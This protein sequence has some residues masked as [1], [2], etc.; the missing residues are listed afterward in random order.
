MHE[1]VEIEPVKGSV[2]QKRCCGDKKLTGDALDLPWPKPDCQRDC[3][4]D[5]TVGAN[6]VDQPL[7]K[8]CCG[9]KTKGDG[10]HDAAENMVE[11]ESVDEL[12]TKSACQK[13]CCGDKLKNSVGEVKAHGHDDIHGTCTTNKLQADDKDV[14][15]RL[16]CNIGC[17]GSTPMSEVARSRPHSHSHHDEDA[18]TTPIVSQEAATEVTVKACCS[19]GSCKKTEIDRSDPHLAL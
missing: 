7:T 6:A 9:D 13:G 8:G 14:D 18:A 2:C 17:C 1:N 12:L 10:D 11:V 16:P 5:E 3:C 19:G 4:G 15:Q